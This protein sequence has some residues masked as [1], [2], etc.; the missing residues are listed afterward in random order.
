ME[1]DSIIGGVVGRLG[2]AVG[3]GTG[4]GIVVA[5]HSTVI[6]GALIALAGVGIDLLVRYVR[7]W[8]SRT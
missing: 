8:F 7:Q 5:D 3:A 2:T 1:K 6:Q 4:T